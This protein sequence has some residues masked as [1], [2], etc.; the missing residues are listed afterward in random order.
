MT[1][2][3]STDEKQAEQQ[4]EIVY[5]DTPRLMLKLDELQ[6]AAVLLAQQS[7][8]RLAAEAAQ[9]EAQARNL[10][11]QAQAKR[12]EGQQ[13][14][15]NIV[16]RVFEQQDAPFPKEA[17]IRIE[18]NERG[19]PGV[20][21]WDIAAPSKSDDETR[22]ETPRPAE[23]PKS[24]PATNGRGAIPAPPIPTARRKAR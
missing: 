19:M 21:L 2:P 12:N 1:E 14:L 8:A 10:T 13:T 18:P 11:Q 7:D 24:G 15:L 9:L 3:M 17:H 16:Q 23:T 20:L 6:S 22:Q 4:D 5:D